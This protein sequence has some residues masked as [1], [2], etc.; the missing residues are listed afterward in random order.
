MFPAGG[1]AVTGMPQRVRFVGSELLCGGGTGT[2]SFERPHGYSFRAGEFFALTLD[3]PEGPISHYFSHADAPGDPRALILT[4]LTGSP[5]KEALLGLAAGDEVGFA[6]PMG[7][8]MLPEGATRAAFLVGGVGVTPAHSIL[9]DVVQRRT[10][11]E[12]LVFDGNSDEGCIPFGEEF[13]V[14]EREVPGVRV[15][16]VLSSPTAAWRGERGHIDVDLVR[17]HCDPLDGW[18][19]FV[20]GPPMMVEAM[21]AVVGELGIPAE[22]AHFELFTGYA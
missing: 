8:L 6:G 10:G 14:Y 4:R 16:P 15:V 3:T 18:E 11:T 19:W 12:V 5:F 20:C 9:R 17:R 1:V 7:R 22:R 2:F 13:A 21:R